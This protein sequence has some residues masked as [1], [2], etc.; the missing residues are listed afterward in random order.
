LQA[1]GTTKA[2]FSANQSSNSSLNITS[3]SSNGTISVGGTDVKVKGLGGAAY[4]NTGTTTNTVAAGDH[5]H[6]GMVTGVTLASGTNNGTL[7]LTVNGSATD[8]IAVKGL[9]TAAY[10][11]EGYFAGSGHSHSNY[12]VTG[13]TVSTASGL[14]GGGNLS[15]NRTIGLAATGTSGT[16]GPAAD[17]TGTEGTTIKVPQI[18]VDE[19]GRV[20]SV[21]ERTLTNKNSTYTAANAA[22][23]KVASA[24]ASGTSGN[25]ARQDHT[26]GIDLATGDSNGQV[27]IAGTNVSVKGLGTAAYKAEGYFAGSGHTHSAYVNQNAWSKIKI[28]A[29]STTIDADTA[30]DTLTISGGSFVTLTSDATNDKFTIGVSTGTS[31]STLA[32]G[33][34]SH[35]SYVNQ[36]AFS[37][38]KVGST[39]VAADTTTDT[40]ELSAATFVTLTP[41]ATNDKVTIGVS[42]GTSSSTLARGDHSH[43]GYATVAFKTVKVSGASTVDV[44]AD[45]KEDTITFAKDDAI[46]LTGDATNDKVTFGL[47]DVICGDYA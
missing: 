27:K 12:V 22:P 38:D 29:E 44:V 23:P 31:S 32:R 21:T 41:D 20:T 39:T 37:N 15:A 4:L 40:L 43:S 16:Y 6:S 25:Y 11:A 2:S 33:D 7:K 18:T 10:K 34:H 5:T 24:S 19:Y 8:N 9:G 1:N 46:T 14:T 36:N 3:G 47:G 45:A 30:T 17:V 13:R 26:H 35:S 28:N 42:T